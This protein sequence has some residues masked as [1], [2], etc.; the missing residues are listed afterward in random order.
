MGLGVLQ[1]A[2]QG[3]EHA[4]ETLMKAGANLGGSDIEGGFAALAM[5]KAARVGDQTSLRIWEKAGEH[6]KKTP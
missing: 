6:I 1:A 5:K 3:H 2:R 4:V